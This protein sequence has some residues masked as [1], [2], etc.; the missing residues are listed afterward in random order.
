MRWIDGDS[1]F[2]GNGDDVIEVPVN[3][4]IHGPETHTWSKTQVPFAV[5][6][7][8]Q[9]RTHVV[10]EPGFQLWASGGHIRVQS[11]GSIS[12]VGSP[13][14]VV[15]FTARPEVPGTWGGFWIESADA[16]NEFEY[17]EIAYG[18]A[19][20]FHNILLGGA[21][22]LEVRDSL[23]RDSAACGIRVPT[24]AS[25]RLSDVDFDNNAGGDVCGP[26]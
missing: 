4:T 13:L 12:A 15:L 7:G 14:D 21:S 22:Y 3:V 23:I 19:P 18:G 10:V 9:V 25:L 5:S 24:G 8:F 20:D 1:T 2:S 16:R 17:V 6:V 11:D 26:P